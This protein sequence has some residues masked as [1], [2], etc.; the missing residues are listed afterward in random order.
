MDGQMDGWTN[1]TLPVSY[2]TLSPL[3]PLPK[4]ELIVRNL[5]GI[6]PSQQTTFHFPMANT[7]S[8]NLLPKKQIP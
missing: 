1:R 7:T 5:M 4:R 8:V 2:R 3:E 6:F